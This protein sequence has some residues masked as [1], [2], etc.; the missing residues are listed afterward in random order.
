MSQPVPHRP[1]LV[2][3]LAGVLLLLGVD[4]ARADIVYLYD[5]LGRLVRVIRDDGEAASYYYDAVGNILQVTRESG[6]NQSGAG[7]H[8][9]LQVRSVPGEGTGAENGGR[10]RTGGVAVARRVEHDAR[11]SEERRVGKEC[12]L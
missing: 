1:E 10:Q 2:L 6:V 12:R 9:P 3:V 4:L 7:D 8:S 11:R 5:D